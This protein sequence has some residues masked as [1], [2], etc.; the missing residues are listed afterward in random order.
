MAAKREVLVRIMTTEH[1][2]CDRYQVAEPCLLLYGV[3]LVRDATVR[4]R[5][6]F[7]NP[8]T[9]ESPVRVTCPPNHQAS[10]ALRSA[11]GESIISEFTHLL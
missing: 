3:W 4:K 1:S 10:E 6:Q 5:A 7:V 9:L 2:P 11:D 8:R